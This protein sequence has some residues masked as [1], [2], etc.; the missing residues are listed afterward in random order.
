MTAARRLAAI[1]AADVVSDSGWTCPGSARASRGD[2]SDLVHRVWLLCVR[3]A[4]PS[5]T[6]RSERFTS[7]CDVK[8]LAA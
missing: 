6:I 7:T 3:P 1:L 2:K 5:A 8:S 4:A